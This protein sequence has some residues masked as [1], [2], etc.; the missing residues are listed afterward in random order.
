[1]A[2]LDYQI[3]NYMPAEALDALIATAR[4]E[5]LGP[6]GVDVTCQATIPPRSGGDAT[7]SPRLAGV[8]AGGALLPRIAEAY[9]PRISVEVLV[10]DGAT[11]TRHEAVARFD[12]PLDSILT[13]ERVALNFVTHLSGIATLTARYVAQTVG[14]RARIYDTRKTVPGLRGLAKYAVTCGGG[15]AHRMGLY[16]AMLVKD[17]HLAG[18]SLEALP[19]V[20]DQAIRRARADNPGIKFVEVEV[21]SLEQ[22]ERVFEVQGVEVVLLDNMGAEQL[23]KAVAR[24]D[25][26]RP[27]M[28]LEASGGVDLETVKAIAEAGVDRIA[29]GAL[30]HSAPALDL[31]L[32]I[33]ERR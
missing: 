13:M 18:V 3:E 30:T 2:S 29:V 5:D 7:M 8:L 21:D 19:R 11:I 24:R 12:G 14:T 16:D 9:D 17:N 20:L 27:G 1:M 4:R 28:A 10:R 6:E 22:L 33:A 25:M 31:G 26:Q 32:D 23:H 15:H